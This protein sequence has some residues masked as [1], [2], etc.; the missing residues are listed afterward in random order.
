MA[1][2]VDFVFSG[3]PPIKSPNVL[4]YMLLYDHINITFTSRK[5]VTSIFLP[6]LVASLALVHQWVLGHS[7]VKG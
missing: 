2:G 3:L 1:T 7:G 5:E 6:T 4:G